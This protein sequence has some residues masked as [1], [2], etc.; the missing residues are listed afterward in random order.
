MQ[1]PGLKTVLSR[2]GA[3]LSTRTIHLLNG[4]FN[5][6]YVGWWM[7]QRG[8]EV[9]ARF[10]GRD[11]LYRYLSSQVKEPVSY[12]EF[13]VYRGNSMRFWSGLLRHPETSFAGFDSFEGLPEIWRTAADKSTFDVKGEMP[14]I[15][16]PRVKLV[17]GWFTDTVPPFLKSYVPKPMLILHLDADLYSSTIFALNQLQPFIKEGTLLIFDEF[18]DK[19][20]ELKALEEFLDKTGM[21]LECI[22]ATPALTQTAFRVRKPPAVSRR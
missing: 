11:E 14:R 7:R 21:E 12:L 1:Y 3:R 17:K 19:E 8:F 10:A 22:A 13:G 4:V 5:Y 15:D 9:P 18:F 2:V 16:D 6:L 20:H